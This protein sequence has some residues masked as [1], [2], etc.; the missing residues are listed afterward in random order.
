MTSKNYFHFFLSMA[1]LAC[2]FP[3]SAQAAG[4]LPVLK[5]EMASSTPIVTTD[6]ASAV[7]IDTQSGSV[8]YA[9]EP[10]KV[11]P[12]ASLTKLMTSHVFTSTPTKWASNTTILKTDEVGG[13]RLQVASGSVFTFRDMLYSA[14]IGSANNCAEALGRL[15][16]PKQGK[17]AFITQMNERARSL[18][19]IQSSYFDAS[20][21]D[22]RNTL[23]AYDTAVVISETAEDPEAAKAMS[24]ATYS[25]TL[26]KPVVKKTIKSTNDLLFSQKDLI[27]TAGKTGFINEAKYNFVVRAYPKGEPEKELVAVVLG[28][29]V[30]KDSIEGSLAL[31]RWAW[32]AHVWKASSTSIGLKANRELGDKGEDI[33]TLQQY[34]NSRGFKVAVSGAGSPGKETTLFGALTKAALIRYQEAHAEEI[35]TPRGA[36]AGSGYLD[37]HTRSA[38]NRG[39]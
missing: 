1:I 15:F 29:D 10:A 6:I 38:M 30:R 22:E 18:G 25:F 28:A 37:Y 5:P 13:G 11:W 39:I 9:Y 34:L 32:G 35:L 16:N 33:R 24:L 23:S 26:K 7:L 27:I 3:F 2:G 4:S 31:M 20:G 21:M 36:V 8:L 12:A 19:L 14:L 17:D